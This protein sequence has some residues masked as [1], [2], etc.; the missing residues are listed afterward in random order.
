MVYEQTLSC[1]VVVRC[2]AALF[3]LQGGV[4]NQK[5]RLAELFI[6]PFSEGW[7]I[8]MFSYLL[9]GSGAHL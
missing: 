9:E 1:F 6:F 8:Q 3:M 2:A 4:K 5:L 7:H